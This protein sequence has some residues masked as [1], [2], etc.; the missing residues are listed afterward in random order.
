MALWAEAFHK[1]KYPSVCLSV[2]LSV[3]PPV[4][5]FTFE[6]PFKRL[7]APTSRSWMSNIFRD[8]ESLGKSNGKKR[9]QIWT[10]FVGSGLKSPRKKKV[11]FLCADFA[12]KNMVKTTLCDWL[13]TFGQRAYLYFLHIIRLF[14][15]FAFRMIFYV[16]Q[17]HQVFR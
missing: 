8:S 14:W 12:F 4:C 10:F 15:V 5:L 17:K 11:F 2:C 7:F 13:V 3:C 1:S 16:F 6:E 9:S